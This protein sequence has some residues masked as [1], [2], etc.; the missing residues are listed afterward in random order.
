MHCAC[1]VRAMP[2][3]R[4][5]RVRGPVSAHPDRGVRLVVILPTDPLKKRGY[6]GLNKELGRARNTLT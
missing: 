3:P 6:A 2:V 5:R 1:P 4:S